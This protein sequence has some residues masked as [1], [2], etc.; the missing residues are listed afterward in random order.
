VTV[1]LFTHQACLAHDTGPMH[2]ERPDRL[3]AILAA[4]DAPEFAA[5]LRAEAPQATV[6]QLA[7]V[8]PAP[9][10]EAILA[11]QPAGQERTHLDADT[12]MSAGSAAAALHA[13]GAGV[14]AVDRVM[15]GQARA[16]F[17]AVR[18]PGHHAEVARP[19]GFCLFN[20]A[21][22]AARHAQARWGLA[23]V[24]VLDFDVHHG[25][26]TEDVF[27]RD[28]SVF[29]GSSHQMPLYPGTGD[30]SE[31]GVGNIVN[32][33]LEAG[34]NGATFVAAWQNVIMPA[35]EDFAPDLL[36][37][38]A[39]FDAHR[40]DPLANLAVGTEDFARLTTMLCEAADRLCRGRVVSLLEGGYDL[41]ALASS[42]AAH[43]RALMRA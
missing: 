13:A 17:C 20:S 30:P 16:A 14:A 29:Y 9:Y 5:L 36:V 8:H 39:G 15:Q 31:R 21:A 12:L 1:A 18:P 43:V 34:S 2:P 22:V 33:A 41:D 11:I 26:G 4:L 24:A 10:I 40:R 23:R 6:E 7:R 25:N 28:A 38:S 3:R 27:R 37:I 19:M 42:T 32:V 35:L